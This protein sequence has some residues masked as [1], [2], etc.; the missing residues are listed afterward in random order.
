MADSYSLGIGI[1]S[2]DE[3]QD[4]FSILS[5]KLELF[6]MNDQVSDLYLLDSFTIPLNLQLTRCWTGLLGAGVLEL[7]EEVFGVIDM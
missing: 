4:V 6:L 2:P 3:G 5:L 1:T 7:K